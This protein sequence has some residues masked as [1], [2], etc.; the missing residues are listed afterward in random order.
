MSPKNSTKPSK[1]LGNFLVRDENGHLLTPFDRPRATLKREVEKVL[2]VVDLKGRIPVISNERLSGNPHSGGFDAK[3]IADRI[4]EAFP[5]ARILCLI[6]EQRDMI[7]SLYY[8]YL[9]KGGTE[10]LKQYLTR[11]R[12]TKMPYFRLECLRYFDLISYYVD[13][14]SLRN[15]VVLP[16]EMFTEDPA[17]FL[18]RLGG[19]LSVDLSK[20]VGKTRILHNSRFD[21]PIVLRFPK[22]NVFLRKSSLN[23]YSPVYIPGSRRF[24]TKMVRAFSTGSGETIQK[25]REE[26]QTIVQDYFHNSNRNLSALVDLDLS[27]YGYYS[28]KA[29]ATN[30]K[31]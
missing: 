11:R 21:D 10:V 19:F 16:Y 27:R 18:R 22:L 1:Y 31:D 25:T 15:I 20:Y 14:F 8:Q 7:L 3:D 28:S 30:S 17:R 4:M 5:D 2:K 6:R 26:I 24:L 23:A 12:D 29:S 13:L 9:R